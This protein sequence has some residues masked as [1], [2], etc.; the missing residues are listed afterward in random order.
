MEN[1]KGSKSRKGKECE[2]VVS[3]PLALIT[4]PNTKNNEN[5]TDENSFPAVRKKKNLPTLT[6]VTHLLIRLEGKNI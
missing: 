1:Q 3:N 4:P 6:I 2:G 5:P